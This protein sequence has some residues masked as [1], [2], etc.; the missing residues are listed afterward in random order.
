MLVDVSTPQRLLVPADTSE[1]IMLEN[2][3]AGT[4]RFI[5]DDRVNQP[6]QTVFTLSLCPRQ[7]EVLGA[8]AP[9]VIP[10][11][12]GGTLPANLPATGS[13]GVRSTVV[14]LAA[15]VVTGV[16]AA[17]RPRPRMTFP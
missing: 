15:S 6:H 4:Y 5:I 11:E 10:G 8:T 3:T 9:P 17:L 16:I 12:G 14:A 2:L 7:G 13:T 1:V